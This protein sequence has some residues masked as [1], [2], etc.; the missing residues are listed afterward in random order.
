MTSA[1][2]PDGVLW[3]GPFQ[4]WL[5]YRVWIAADGS[6]RLSLEIERRHL[7]QYGVGHGGVTLALLDTVGGVAVHARAG[8]PAR[9]VTVSLSTSFTR[10]VE[11]GPVL[12]IGRVEYLG[13]T[14]AHTHAELRA[15][16]EAGELLALAHGAYRIFRA[17]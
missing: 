6:A 10:G 16:S 3:T 2:D 9:L 15:G 5:G 4:D 11:P 14:I 12:A 17:G 8:G 13:R 1:G 7:S